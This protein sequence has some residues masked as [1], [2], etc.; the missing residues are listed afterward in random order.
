VA[1]GVDVDHRVRGLIP[2]VSPQATPRRQHAHEVP[3]GSV[4]Q[5]PHVVVDCTHP[6]EVEVVVKRMVSQIPPV[7][8][9]AGPVP[10]RL[11][12]SLATLRDPGTQDGRELAVAVGERRFGGEQSE[13]LEAPLILAVPGRGRE[14]LQPYP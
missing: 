8:L 10:Q 6:E 5:L 14:R 7:L 1:L 9:R 12:H 3:A 11:L 4:G 13:R 2:V